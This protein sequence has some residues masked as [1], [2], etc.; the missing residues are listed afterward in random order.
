MTAGELTQVGLLGH[1][2]TAMAYLGLALLVVLRGRSTTL[3]GAMLAL[4]SAATF[5]WAAAVVYDL[6]VGPDLG[7]I[8]QV[9]EVVRSCGWLV[10]ILS[11]LYW[12]APVRRTSWAAAVGGVCVSVAALT[13]FLRD[14]P[15]TS[16]FGLMPIG[17]HLLLALIGLALV[18]NLFRNSPRER[19]WII[20]YLCLGVGALFAYDFYFYANALLFHHLDYDLFVARGVTNLLVMPLIAVYATRDRQSGRQVIVSRHVAFHSATVLSAGFYLIAMAAAGYY[21]R[22]F[23]G[24]WSSFLQAIFVFGSLLVLLVPL[25]S[26]RVRAYFR[27]LVEKSF[28]KY[29][30]DYRTEWLRFIE[31]MSSFR[32]GQSLRNRVIKAVADI[33]DSPEGAIWLDR[34]AEGYVLAASWNLSRW[35][36][37]ESEATVAADSSLVHF[38]VETRWVINLDELAAAPERY[39]GLSGL[40]PWVERFPRAWLILPL[41]HHD[42]LIGI[43]MLGRPRAARE[44]SW[45]DFDLL[46]TVARQAASYLA[47][48]AASEALLEARQFEAF[49]KRFAFVV[50]D[51]KNLASQLSLIL[52]NA[53]KYRGN[54][55]FQ[56][57]VIETV[58][59]SVEKMHRMLTQL[60]APP[61][62]PA[63]S[64]PVALAPLLRQI[65]ATQRGIGPAISLDLQADKVAVA[66]DEDRLKA[67]VEQLVQNA[68]EAVGAAGRVQVR[69][70]GEGK[71]A[72]VEIEDN[73]P[74]M[75]AD[76]VRDKLFLPFSSTKDSG[77]GIGVYESRDF[78]SSLGGRLEVT[79]EPGRGTIMRMRLPAVV[80]N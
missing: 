9:F 20:K 41:H 32:S 46:K 18:E 35:N 10:M 3:S 31:T 7:P 21:V 54:A 56:D 45:E 8:A 69:L 78:A 29:K 15:T 71:M 66:A 12:M 43:M 42:E 22:R 44:L 38:L 59:Q 27:I 75:D 40:P 72:V 64:P 39:D 79:S 61:Q 37:N 16:N 77:Y 24:S 80:I 48:H 4:A 13:V 55:R 58:R 53:P 5:V 67:V 17:G 28:F 51:I 70:A 34:G 11:L 23:G 63:T 73:G 57:D 62:M 30:Y 74:G 1:V 25:A 52:S 76:F 36:V 49:N 6:Y 2:A 50:H 26:G 60:H 14:V 47:E 33:V 19:Q 68:V 65:V